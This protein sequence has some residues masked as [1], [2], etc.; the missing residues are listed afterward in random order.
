VLW[1]DLLSGRFLFMRTLKW[2]ASGAG[3]TEIYR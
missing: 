1:L 2:N 3:N